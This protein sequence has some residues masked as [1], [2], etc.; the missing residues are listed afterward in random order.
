MCLRSTRSSTHAGRFVARVDAAVTRWKAA[1]EYDSKQEH[2][3]EFQIASD[4]SRRNRLL[5]AGWTPIVARH[6]DLHRRWSGGR[7][8]DPRLRNRKR[9]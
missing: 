6:G 1:V 9:A 8:R 2:S 5:A 4:N 7:R 3:D